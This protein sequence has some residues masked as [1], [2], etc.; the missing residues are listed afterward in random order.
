MSTAHLVIAQFYRTHGRP[1]PLCA[2]GFSEPR[3]SDASPPLPHL[4][5]SHSPRSAPPAPSFQIMRSALEAMQRSVDG[6]IRAGTIDSDLL[7]P[8]HDLPSTATPS[9]HAAHLPVAVGGCQRDG[10][11]CPRQPN[12]APHTAALSICSGSRVLPQILFLQVWAYPGTL[13]S[14][15]H[16]PFAFQF[17]AIIREFSES[18][19][20]RLLRAP[21]LGCPLSHAPRTS[22]PSSSRHGAELPAPAGCPRDTCQ[23]APH[24]RCRTQ[25]LRPGAHRAAQLHVQARAHR[26]P[27][28]HTHTSLSLSRSAH[29]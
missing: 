22:T 8:H 15:L 6:M 27:P 7:G 26:A 16:L 9:K 1:P 10:P 4:P 14:H 21:W 29:K 25:G 3:A 23:R 2:P 18:L 24:V 17:A 5:S 19:M 11:K 28:A 20:V 12:D 13:P